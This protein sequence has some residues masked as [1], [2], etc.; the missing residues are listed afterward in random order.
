MR[1]RLH[2]AMVADAYQPRAQWGYWETT[3]R[4]EFNFSNVIF[5]RD[6]LH[7]AMVADAYQ[8]RA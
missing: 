2:V 6:R 3:K 1:D 7:V 8:L 5:V 4:K